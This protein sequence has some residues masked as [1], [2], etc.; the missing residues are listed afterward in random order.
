MII[1]THCHIFDE[2]FDGIREEVINEALEMGVKKMIVVGYDYQSSLKAIELAE[3]YDFMYASIGLHPSEV[4]KEK[5][6]SLE[7]IRELYNKSKK[8]V[9]IGE[10]GLDYYWDK[11]FIEEQKDFFVKQIKIASDLNLPIIVHTR[12]SIQ[13]CFNILKDIKIRGVLH[14]FSSSVEMAREFVKR[15]Y[16]IGIGGVVTFKNSVEIKKVAEDIDINYILS[17]TDC[18]YLAPV[19][20]RGKTNH[21][22]YTK[23]V[24]E[25]ISELRGMD[26]EKVEKILEN[27]A[28]SLFLIGDNDE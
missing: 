13:D 10:I 27:N 1:D 21:P 28:N 20:F 4:L 16:Y 17:E 25:K 19:P 8:V 9:A 22:G 11:S 5:D 2:K 7:W 14:C 24:V 26:L 6:K 23:F 12:D 3:K 15:G 18:P